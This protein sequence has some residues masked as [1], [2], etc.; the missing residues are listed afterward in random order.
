MPIRPENKHRYPPD[1]AERRARVLARE[2]NRCKFCGVRNYAVGYREKDGTF[3]P[4]S[5]EELNAD[6]ELAVI[7]IVLTVAHLD[8]KLEDHS[9]EN[10]AALC[11]R[12]HLIYDR[13]HRQ[14]RPFN[15]PLFGKVQ[16]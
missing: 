15:T 9:L 14:P 3:V 13:P 8:H 4:V 16:P 1:W 10:L 12:C 11:Q 6:G 7:R 5:L 2:K